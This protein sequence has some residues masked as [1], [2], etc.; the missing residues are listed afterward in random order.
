MNCDE[1]VQDEV[2]WVLPDQTVLRAAELMAA[3]RVGWL[4]GGSGSAAAEAGTETDGFASH[5][6]SLAAPAETETQPDIEPRSAGRAKPSPLLWWGLGCALLLRLLVFPF[7]ENK[8]A[9]APMRAMLAEYRGTVPGAAR[10]PRTFFQFGPLPIEITQAFLVFGGDVR[11]LS[12]LPSLLAGLALFLPFIALAR[13]LA[14]DRRVVAAATLALALSPLAVQLS[15]TAASEPIY[16][17][18][19]LACLDRMHAALSVTASDEGEGTPSA[20]WRRRRDYLLAG[21]WASLAAVSRYDAWLAIPAATAAAG[22][23]GPR[24]R[25]AMMDLLLFLLT[26]AALPLAYLVWMQAAGI[27]PWLFAR[28]ISGEHA[29]SAAALAAQ[30]GGFAARM[31]QVSVWLLGLAAAMTPV[32][33]LGLPLAAWH[34]RRLSSA[35]RVIVVAALAPMLLYLAKGL[36]FDDF[37][38]LARFALVPGVLLLPLGIAA[39]GTRLSE[40]GL[41]VAVV[42]GAMAFTIAVSIAA[43]GRPGSVRVEAETLAPITR[44]ERDT[45]AVAKYLATHRRP[46]ESVFVDTRDYVDIM[47]AHAARVPLAQVATLWR[48]RMLSDSLAEEHS[49]SQATLFAAHDGS[50]GA[51]PLRDWPSNSVRFGPWRVARME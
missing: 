5:Q 40:R 21:C 32:G 4:P 17:L 29:A 48:T 12:R 22:L 28:I 14:P 49:R 10:D 19:W 23:L 1:L 3:H 6:A 26:A 42:A 24:D 30:V 51:R 27:D 39:L 36:W 44:L 41:G 16:L 13:R 43:Y 46:R 38:P 15:T 31:H 7:A 20:L 50:W 47:I 11:L 2:H 45:R 9:D 35:T 34:W 8:H 33:L 37:E 25:R 18:F